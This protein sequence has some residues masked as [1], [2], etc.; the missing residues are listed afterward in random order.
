MS[1]TAARF[2]VQRFKQGDAAPHEDRFEVEVGTRTTVLDG[3]VSIRRHQDPTLTLR[4][5]CFHASCGT[6]G[7]RIN[8]Q[9]RLACVTTIQELGAGE[10]VVQPLANA[11]V[12]SDLVVDMAP[13]YARFNPTERGL[14]RRSELV[15][16][17]TTAPGI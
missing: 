11:P 13:F 17:A 4:H 12:V 10:V 16:G 2:R 3:L 7:M 15:K 8:G 14:V 9:E 1:D 5:S 6:C